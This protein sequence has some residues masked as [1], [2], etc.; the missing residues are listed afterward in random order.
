MKRL[1]LR[2]SVRVKLQIEMTL[3][4]SS[5]VNAA[6]ARRHL[7]PEVLALMIIEGVLR[8]GSID[9]CIN[10]AEPDVDDFNNL[11]TREYGAK[12]PAEV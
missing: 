9:R 4:T 8:R 10:A 6:A 2:Q 12:A 11:V 5:A 3:K 1:G 7:K